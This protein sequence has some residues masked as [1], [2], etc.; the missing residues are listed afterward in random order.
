MSAPLPPGEIGGK[1]TSA[2][3]KLAVGAIGIVFGDIGTS[4]IYAFRETFVG[5]HPL[6][7]DTL[8][9]MGVVSLIFWAMTIIVSLQYV[10]ILMRAD[11]K[12]QG[13]TLAL[14][15]LI[16]RKIGSTNRSWIAVMLGVFATSLFYGDSMITPAVS[17]LS[18]VEGLTT[19]EAGL[20]DFVIPIALALLIALFLLQKRG[21][22]SIGKLFS[23]IMLVYFSTLAVLGISHILDFPGVLAALNP[24]YAVQFFMTDKL[25]GFLALGSVVLAVTGAEALYTDMGHFG[26]GPLR[27][28]WFGFAMPCLLLN[29]FGQAA[30]IMNLEAAA[31]AEAIQNPFFLMASEAFRLPL[32]LLATAATFIASQ[33]VISG[34][35]SV[36]QQAIQLGFVPRLSI[37]HTSETEHGQVYIP[38]VNWVLMIAVILLV[39]TF[40]NS[41]NLASAYGIAVTGAMLIDTCLMAVLFVAVWRWKLW[42]ALPIA[43]VFFLFDGAFFAANLPKVPDGGWFPL[44]VGAFAFTLLTTWA[45]GRQLMRDRMSE[46]ALPIAIFAKSAK[47]SATRVPGTAIFMASTTGGV[48]SALLHNIKHNKVLH[49]RVVILTIEIADVPYVDPIERF[50]IHSVSDGLYRVVLHFGF[51]EET[52]VP[53][54]LKGV[55]SCGGMFDMMHTSFFL[56]RQTLIASK[57][58]GMAIW[59]EKLFAWML[60]NS[61]T[62]MS[63]FRLPTNRVVELGSQLE[64]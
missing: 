42:L 57:R 50:E 60:R 35:F 37:L 20:A 45:R 58:P 54:A 29:Y 51:M 59:R 1:S 10:A 39:L 61:A 9:L 16:S 6:T 33:A 46:V 52:D 7:L 28:S 5:P 21:T 4:P 38:F 49:E 2:K 32:V 12:G 55:E 3:V 31:A 8:H 18:A 34:A 43:A 30:M 40:R 23:P 19:V 53:A 25:L 15:A 36:T 11:N 56:S 26:R 22:A 24:W 47:N 14:V 62:A 41:S 63:F 17:V 44:L 48:P 13:G 64:I 27:I